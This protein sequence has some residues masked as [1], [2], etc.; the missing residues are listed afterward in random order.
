MSTLK[1]HPR[2]P[3]SLQYFAQSW[4]WLDTRAFFPHSK[5]PHILRIMLMPAQKLMSMRKESDFCTLVTLSW[6]RIFGGSLVR[7]A[8]FPHNQSPEFK[9]RFVFF[10]LQMLCFSALCGP[11][12]Q[13]FGELLTWPKVITPSKFLPNLS[14]ERWETQHLKAKK[15]KPKFEFRTLIRRHPLPRSSAPRPFLRVIKPALNTP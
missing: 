8:I 5:S 12:E 7:G 11:N 6:N 4:S 9:F 14:T 15:H 10:R 1:C 3:P 13:K 2:R